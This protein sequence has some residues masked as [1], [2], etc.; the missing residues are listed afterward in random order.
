[1]R[2]CNRSFCR[3]QSVMTCSMTYRIYRHKKSYFASINHHDTTKTVQK[4]FECAPMLF[5]GYSMHVARNMFS[6]ISGMHVNMS[7]HVG[8][9]RGG[10]Q[11]DVCQLHTPA[12]SARLVFLFRS[13]PVLAVGLE[14]R[15]R[16]FRESHIVG[17]SLP[18]AGAC[19][20]PLAF[21]TQSRCQARLQTNLAAVHDADRITSCDI[22][23]RY[24][25][26]PNSQMMEMMHWA[27]VCFYFDLFCVARC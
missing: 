7:G 27:K 16:F 15:Q 23:S 14:V 1:M 4:E 17:H 3:I 22:D 19:L 8:V 13:K 9:E 11:C 18:V 6:R 21:R 5:V 20:L 24:C 12:K 26:C 2:I 25:I 10:V